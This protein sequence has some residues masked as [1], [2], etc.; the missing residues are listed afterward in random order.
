MKELP[1]TALSRWWARSDLMKE[2]PDIVGD[3]ERRVVALEAQVPTLVPLAALDIYA[4]DP[5]R[6]SSRPCSTCANISKV[7]GR[8]WGCVQS[9]KGEAHERET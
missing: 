8:N 3:L 9:L 1:D 6:F 4:R 5:H 2:L 7:I